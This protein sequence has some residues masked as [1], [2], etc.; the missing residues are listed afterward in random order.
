MMVREQQK[1]DIQPDSR[2]WKAAN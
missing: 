1:R 2:A